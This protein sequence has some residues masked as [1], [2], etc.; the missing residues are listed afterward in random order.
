[1][2]GWDQEIAQRLLVIAAELRILEEYHPLFADELYVDV[3]DSLGNLLR[4]AHNIVGQLGERLG[5]AR[6]LEMI[7]EADS[8]LQ[9]S[10]EGRKL[11]QRTF[12]LLRFIC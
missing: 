10:I 9:T 3:V 12:G 8:I 4:E 11:L 6:K 5:T 7:R 2:G 1:M